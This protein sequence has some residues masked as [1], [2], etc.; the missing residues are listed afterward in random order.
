MR[1]RPN[2]LSAPVP[3]SGA[4]D[5]SPLS[6]ISFHALIFALQLASLS[7]LLALSTML[8]PAQHAHD[9]T[10]VAHQLTKGPC[11]FIAWYGFYMVS[12][13]VLDIKARHDSARASHDWR[14]FHGPWSACDTDPGAFVNRLYFMGG[15]VFNL[16]TLRVCLL[17]SPH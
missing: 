11:G 17:L 9:L 14:H 1:Y 15:L 12:T 16:L 8:D 13:I 5:S 4:Q 3:E 2:F 7:A 10:G 6:I